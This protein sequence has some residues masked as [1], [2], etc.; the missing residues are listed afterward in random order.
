MEN[1]KYWPRSDGIDR[2]ED[3]QLIISSIPNQM[4]LEFSRHMTSLLLDNSGW[5]FIFCGL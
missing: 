4:L 1:G 2:K 5:F 3:D